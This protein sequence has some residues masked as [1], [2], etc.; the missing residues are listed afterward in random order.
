MSQNGDAMHM[1][2]GFGQIRKWLEGQKPKASSMKDA[3]PFQRNLEL[4][5]DQRR[6]DNNLMT[7][8]TFEQEVD[9]SSNDFLSLATSG[10]LRDAFLEEIKKNPNF[11]VGSTASRVS[12][13]NNAYME[14]LEKKIAEFH[15]AEG[16]LLVGS[17]YD[18]NCAIF[19]AV[20][21]PGDAIV[22]DE[23]IH[24]SAHDGMKSSLALTQVPFKHNSA[25]NLRDVLIELK[26]SQSLI[27]DGSR[28]VLVAVESVYSM[29]GDVTPLIDIVEVLKELFPAGNAQIIID[30][31][32]STGLIGDK[33][34]GLV[35]E[36]GLEKEIAIRLHTYGKGLGATGVQK[37]VQMFCDIIREDETWQDAV[38]AGI[39]SIP[40]SEN[41]ESRPFVTQF[42]PVWTRQGQNY[43]LVMHL[44][45][46][47]F[48]A[49]PIDPP[50]VPRGTGRVRIIIHAGNTDKQVEGLAASV[51]RWAGEMLDLQDGETG[52]NKVPS[53][54]RE[55]YK[56][57]QAANVSE[58]D[59]SKIAVNSYE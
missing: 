47:G 20:P 27:R 52:G 8:H 15:G 31:A 33:G 39:C 42:L 1:R 59:P 40:L 43:F 24:A 45:R 49:T 12:D 13:G 50:V 41:A 48:N 17:G 30:E 23:L 22:Y 18:A 10:L 55:V 21:R 32:H 58:L 53:A 57:A 16:A 7:L 54:M 5:L 26:N 37:L 34:R 44:L 3:S 4:A 14:S 51:I 19:S 25:E 38:D 36:L 56:M 35:C 2:Q 29:D 28:C 9:F 6:V 11:A 46:D